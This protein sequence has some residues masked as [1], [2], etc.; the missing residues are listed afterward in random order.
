MKKIEKLYLAYLK[1][2]DKVCHYNCVECEYRKIC[3]WS[4]G[5]APEVTIE[6]VEDIL[7]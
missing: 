7:K 1:E 2:L 3:E 4:S 6:M 5:F